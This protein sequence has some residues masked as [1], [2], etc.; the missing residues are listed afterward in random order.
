M[1]KSPDVAVSDTTYCPVQ[2]LYSC[3]VLQG[4]ASPENS[5][6]QA[7]NIFLTCYLLNLTNKGLMLSYIV[8]QALV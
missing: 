4:K 1:F 3:L 8:F 2:N 6:I 5:Q 7:N